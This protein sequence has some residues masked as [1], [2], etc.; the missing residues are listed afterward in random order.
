LLDYPLPNVAGTRD[1]VFYFVPDVGYG[2]SAR[3]FFQ[4]FYR[5][6]V[7]H[8]VDRL[9][10]LIRTLQAD[11]TTN[12]VQHIRELVIVSHGTPLGLGMPLLDSTT[13]GNESADRLC[14]R[15]PGQ[16]AGGVRRSDAV[17]NPNGSTLAAGWRARFD[18]V[19]EAH[20]SERRGQKVLEAP[21]GQVLHRRVVLG[22]LRRPDGVSV[23][24]PVCRRRRS[25]SRTAIT[26][27]PR[28]GRSR[29]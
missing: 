21:I 14:G 3:R 13:D 11:V 24:W 27:R 25:V 2:K 18:T 5:Q 19:R 4:E 1:Y 10:Q 15:A 6:H 20:I 29:C 16:D 7:D 8:Q 23:T 28:V 22:D 26:R 9:E 17:E 12:G